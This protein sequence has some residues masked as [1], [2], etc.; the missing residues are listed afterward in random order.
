MAESFLS[1]AASAGLIL[2]A[3]A[4]VAAIEAVIPLRARGAWSRAHLGP[5]LAL[6]A[7]TFVTYAGFNVALVATLAWLEPMDFG[8]LGMLGLPGPIE[9]LLAVV[10]LDLSTWAA[11]VAMHELPV[12]WR[13]HR[14]HHSDPMLDVTTSLRQH[15]GESVVRFTALAGAATLLGASPAGFAIYRAWSALQALLEHSNI[16]VPVRLDRLLA[17][18][19]VTPNMHKVH[20]SRVRQETDTN[21]GN[22]LSLFDRL[23]STFT[24]SERGVGVA[25]GLEGHDDPATQTTAGLLGLPF[26]SRAPAAPARMA[27]AGA[28]PSHAGSPGQG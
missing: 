4:V 8:L 28:V 27:R 23:F 1:A 26:R 3:M 7:I 18:L 21:Y 5:N 9:L 15:P 13:F 24:P 14:V 11:H 2:V 17:L 19:V 12:L 6:T 10:A 16:R 22:I 25:Y 20:H